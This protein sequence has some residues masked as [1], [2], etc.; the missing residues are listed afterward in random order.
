VKPPKSAA[1]DATAASFE[2][3]RALPGSVPEVVRSAIWQA[4]RL[5]MPTPRVLDLGAGTG[6]FGKAFVAAGDSYAGIDMSLAMLLEFRASC[7]NAFLAQ[8]DGRQ[9]PFCN[10]AFDVVLLMQVLSGASDWQSVLNEA[11][12][13]L[14]RG[15][16]VIVGHTVSPESGIDAQLKRRLRDILEEMKVAWH[17]SQQS[18]KHALAFLESISKLNTHLLASSWNVKTTA[19]E[20]LQRHRTGARFAALPVDIQEEALE[21]LRAWAETTF[22]SV[23]AEFREKR[24]FELDIFEF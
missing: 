23:D 17:Q 16:S 13:V 6:R 18:R 20:F 8:A 12:R 19:R 1:F 9:L 22:G 21:K 14:R 11:R 15:G 7:K 24:S 5:P 3:H 10:G 4:V 2:R